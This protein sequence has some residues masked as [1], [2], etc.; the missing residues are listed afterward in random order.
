MAETIEMPKLSDTME[1]GTLIKWFKSVGDKVSSGDILAEVETDKATMELESFDDGV[2]LKLFVNEGDSVAV[3]APV[4]IIGAEGETPPE[5]VD[6]SDS[7]KE[8]SPAPAKSEDSSPREAIRDPKP[9][10]KSTGSSS[11][12]KDSSSSDQRIKASPL[13]RKIAASRGVDLASVTGSGPGGR[14]VKAD[15]LAHEDKGDQSASS[16]KDEASRSK[17]AP[18][19][20]SLPFGEDAKLPVSTMRGVIAKRLLQ[21]KTEI[22]HFYLQIEVDAAPLLELR[23]ALNLKLSDLSPEK[24]GIKLTVNDFILKGAAETLRRVPTANASWGGDHIA[25][26]GSVHLAFAVSVEDGLVTPTIRDAHAKSLRQ[27]SLEAKELIGKAKSKKLKPDEMSGSTFTVTNLGMFG[28][29]SF[30]GIINPPNAAI[31]SI[32]A[33]V[34]KPVVD[35]N[36]NIV[37]G[38]RM[39]VGLSGDHRV[40]DGAVG[41][42]YL[43]VLKEILETP[44]LM[45]V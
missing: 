1:T 9:S 44:A 27:I 4:A 6:A 37:I 21:S 38:H 28:I 32:G 35:A 19:P 22:P 7:S 33:T 29:S 18:T 26:H 12:E 13:A 23:A 14:I 16:A 24:G 2:I 30:Y 43:S 40:V 15:V 11:V 10:E 5:D 42:E 31:L 3:G 34:K 17:S 8:P 45:L 39:M 41:A 25:T 36:D 20:P